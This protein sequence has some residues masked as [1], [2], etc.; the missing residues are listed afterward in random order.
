MEIVWS[1]M[2]LYLSGSVGIFCDIASIILVIVF[3]IC[4]SLLVVV[5]DMCFGVLVG[6]YT[7]IEEMVCRP[8]K[9]QSQGPWRF[10]PDA[11][12]I[13]CNRMAA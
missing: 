4:I 8:R 10:G 5:F 9:W 2:I 1:I 3:G 12:A 7:C 11:W 13:L 6:Y